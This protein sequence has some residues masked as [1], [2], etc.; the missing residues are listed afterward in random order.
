MAILYNIVIIATC[1]K[2]MGNLTQK[3]C[4]YKFHNLQINFKII[5]TIKLQISVISLPFKSKLSCKV[6]KKKNT[7]L[8]DLVT[9]LSFKPF[10]V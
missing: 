3:L 10:L 2:V 7:A 1:K 9:P 4:G 8:V 6:C 5:R